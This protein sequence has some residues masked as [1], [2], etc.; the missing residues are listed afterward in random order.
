MLRIDDDLSDINSARRLE[1]VGRSANSLQN[2]PRRIEV[3]HCPLSLAACLALQDLGVESN[4]RLGAHYII[5]QDDKIIS[6]SHSNSRSRARVSLTSVD[7]TVK[8]VSD[9]II[10]MLVEI[11]VVMLMVSGSVPIQLGLLHGSCAN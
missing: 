7:G 1:L 4:V 5:P 10:I 2:Q 11:L 3:I 6:T 9:A 8:D